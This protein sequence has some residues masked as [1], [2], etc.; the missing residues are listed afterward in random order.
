[1]HKLELTSGFIIKTL[2]LVV[3]AVSYIPNYTFPQYLLFFTHIK[4]FAV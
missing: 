1:M 3:K 2:S 4:S